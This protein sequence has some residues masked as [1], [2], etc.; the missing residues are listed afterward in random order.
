MELLLIFM[1]RVWHENRGAA[2]DGN[3]RDCT[4]TRTP[5]YEICPRVG[6][7]HIV[8]K[9]SNCQSV[10]LLESGISVGDESRLELGSTGLMPYLWHAGHRSD[11]QLRERFWHRLVDR[12]RALTST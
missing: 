2:S 6:G 3:F 5:Y 7:S 10:I 8:N 9:R 12:Q 4:G 1:V 11:P